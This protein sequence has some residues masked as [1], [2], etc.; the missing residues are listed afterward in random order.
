[1][2][3]VGQHPGVG[4]VAVQAG[5]EHQQHHAHLVALAAEVL[6]R[7][8]VAELVQHLGDASVIASH[9]Q[10]CA[11]K[12]EWNDGQPRVEDVELHDAPA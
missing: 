8:A 10:F 2:P 1:M 4:D 6:A 7:Q 3:V 9:S 11:W 12:N 5:R